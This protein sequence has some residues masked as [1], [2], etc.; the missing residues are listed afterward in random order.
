[1]LRGSSRGRMKDDQTQSARDNAVW[2]RIVLV[3]VTGALPLFLVALVLIHVAYSDAVDFGL[4]EQRGNAF[5]RPLEHLLELVPAYQLAAR[6]QLAGE[7]AAGLTLTE[8]RREIDEG[9]RAVA[10]AYDGELGRALQFSDAE[11]LAR[12]RPNARLSVVR[13][14]W[15]RLKQAPLEV[16][17]SAEGTTVILECLRS[18]I[19]HAGDTSNLVLDDDLDSFY[20]MDITLAALPQTEQR[21]TEITTRV[22]AWLR[23]GQL[24]ENAQQIAVMA[25]LLRQ[26]DLARI[27]RDAQTSL[28]EDARFN[29]QSP[30]LQR[31]LPAAVARLEAADQ[32][33]LALLDRIVT[34]QA[35]SADELEAAGR[36][37]SDASFRLFDVGVSELDRLLAAR[38][39]AIRSRRLQAYA[40]I[41]ATLALA[42]FAMGL[43][44]RS[45][46]LARY[47]EMLK[48]QEQLR[49]KEAQLRTLDD[50]LPDGMTYQV[51]RDF[52]G[53]MR[54]LY[55]S[56]GVQRLHG[57]SAEAVL[58]DSAALY[59]Q[60]FAQDLPTLRAAERESLARMKAF[61]VVARMRRRD[62]AERW[63][64]LFS[65]PRKLADGRIVWDG[66][67]LDVT[68]RQLA[69]AARRQSEERFAR[70]FEK[71]P[72][73]ITLTRLT[74][75][76]FIDANEGFFE[77]S[78]F[79]REEVIGHTSAELN[80]Y[81]EPS[82][83]AEILD[84]LRLKGH[85]HGHSL[86]FRTKRGKLKEN[87]IWLDVIS[88]AGEKCV[89]AI[90]LD[91]TEQKA[92]EQ[93]QK[94]L[95]EQLRQAQKLD[96][97]G[98]LA[99][100][101][102]HD[103]NNILGAIIS[104]SEL[105]KL[106]NPDNAS[107]GQYL[108]EILT[109][110]GR[111]A[112]LVRQILSFSRRQKE[113][114]S[115]IQLAPIA[116]E[117]LSLLRAT[118][119]STIALQ[120]KLD[121]ALPD[122]LANATQVHQIVMNLCTNAAHAM[123]GTQGQISVEL[124]QLQIA[125]ERARPHVELAPGDYVRLAIRDTGHGMDA[126]TL[127]RIFEPF[128]TTKPAGEGTGLGLSVVHGI[129]K[130]YGGVV[131]VESELGRGTSFT[132]YLP[133]LSV[134]EQ[135]A[136]APSADVPRGTGQCILFVDDEPVLGAAAQKMLERLGYRAVVFRSSE[137]ALSAFEAAPHVYDALITDFTMP[138][139]TG[140][141]LSRRLLAIRPGFPIIIASG[142]TGTLTNAEVRQ[143]GI[144]EL[145]SKPLSYASLARVLHQV[146]AS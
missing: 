54:F 58:A 113:E 15:L 99:G 60:I 123:K 89:L 128:F 108:D 118:L 72:M 131:T 110:S 137:A 1:M 105:S 67:E 61:K 104:Y 94:Q 41:V 53:T 76:K 121:G 45:L 97:L 98:T 6:R 83:R 40:V 92:A 26:A 139:M 96:A 57:V 56:G 66:I 114:R 86:K 28:S 140:I 119:P 107:L 63:M 115:A 87:V 69:E 65:S 5:E 129:V 68:D 62:G 135:R 100:G 70:I 141:E 143:L 39:R 16:A 31:N 27:T 126:A 109:A 74:D 88:V 51:L 95:E 85:L 8:S 132:I 24:R 7:P 103:F 46:L 116:R 120:Q 106:D 36:S 145:L 18:M 130:E 78:G 138:G 13:D 59:G 49:A 122:V 23:L 48:T 47:A 42:S 124:D 84:Q 22:G 10:A 112:T 64:E 30:S 91:V 34:D 35:V 38:V 21:L 111:A 125:S 82:E 44:T 102:A 37:A 32:R 33:L 43:I 142:S 136:P 146:L 50:N 52:D 20:V 117:A 12:H 79:T 55:V 80:V 73:P 90:S 29:G 4:Q 93:Q 127:E 19:Q 14:A 3:G 133:A 9:L 71:S 17:A 2:K 11:L 101:I 81:P 134:T 77:F 75:G 25:A 144:R